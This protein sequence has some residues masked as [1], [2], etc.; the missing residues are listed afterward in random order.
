M[1]NRKF[2]FMGIITFAEIIKSNAAEIVNALSL[3]QIYVV[4]MSSKKRHVV[5]TVIKKMK[6]LESVESNMSEVDPK[7]SSQLISLLTPKMVITGELI[8]AIRKN[9][10]NRVPSKHHIAIENMLCKNELAFAELT[11]VHKLLLIQLYQNLGLIVSTIGSSIAESPILRQAD[12][13]ISLKLAEHELVKTAGQMSLTDNDLTIIVDGINEGRQLFVKLKRAVIFMISS[14]MVKVLPFVITTICGVPLAISIPM[15]L[16][17]SLIIETILAWGMVSEYKQISH[18]ARQPR[19]PST[20]MIGKRIFG[21]SYL[22]IGLV[23]FASAFLCY[24][25]I[26]NE[27]GFPP[28]ALFW[29]TEK[30]YFPHSPTD[31]FTPSSKYF[32]NSLVYCDMVGNLTSS[33]T[34]P[35]S[36]SKKSE[37]RTTTFLFD[38]LFAHDIS[39]DL[40]MGYLNDTCIDG[41]IRQSVNFG[42][43]LQHQ[44]SSISQKPICYTVESLRYAQ[45]GYFISITISQIIQTVMVRNR[46]DHL[47]HF[48]LFDWPLV[49]S[50]IGAVAFLFVAVF[51]RPLNYL[52]GT[53]DVSFLHFGTYGLIPTMMMALWD[54]LQKYML[55]KY[56]EKTKVKLN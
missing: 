52:L 19:Q 25:I 45:T 22:Q 12:V 50:W 42:E 4:C 43:C 47:P 34:N 29:V 53:R 18:S 16:F 51:V 31:K 36:L 10:K 21:F 41:I 23:Q 5:E 3:A 48:D 1:E 54:E 8:S 28:S 38:W 14:T 37:N 30:P 17:H 6:N 11:P 39:Q 9:I 49:T 24:L 32:G 20:H 13:G 7:S 44:I 35:S 46:G 26:M 15:I 55:K 27:F 33:V 2:G 56:R 40:R